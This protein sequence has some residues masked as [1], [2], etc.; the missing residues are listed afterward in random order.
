MVP[1]VQGLRRGV[2]WIRWI[3]W[4]LQ[5][6]WAE[7]KIVIELITYFAVSDRGIP[8][9]GKR[10]TSRITVTLWCA[11]TVPRWLLFRMPS[12]PREC[13]RRQ[14]GATLKYEYD[15]RRT[16]VWAKSKYKDR[17]IGSLN[18]G[19][20]TTE[21]LKCRSPNILLECARLLWQLFFKYTTWHYDDV[22]HRRTRKGVLEYWEPWALS[23]GNFRYSVAREQTK[24]T[25]KL[26]HWGC[27]VDSARWTRH[28]SN[29][30]G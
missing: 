20:Q 11:T 12:N 10:Q 28:R 25:F 4:T 16:N 19:V 23:F 27:V 7:N 15:Y 24:Q 6:F 14:L 5:C 13:F 3:R 2:R 18:S 8:G 26:N 1:L 29:G 22:E 21:I 9:G 30:G 17:R